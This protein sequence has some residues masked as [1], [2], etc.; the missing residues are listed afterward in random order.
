MYLYDFIHFY[1]WIWQMSLQAMA[2]HVSETTQQYLGNNNY[3]L[4]QRGSITIKVNKTT[5]KWLVITLYF[6]YFALFKGAFGTTNCKTSLVSLRLCLLP[7]DWSNWMWHKRNVV[8]DTVF[9]STPS[10]IWQKRS[11]SFSLTPFWHLFTCIY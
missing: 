4:K 6:M 10:L 9:H 3:Y 7:N 11:S 5:S 2:A 8:V 1:K